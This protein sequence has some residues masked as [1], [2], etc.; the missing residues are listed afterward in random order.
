MH[1][2]CR[3]SISA[4]HCSSGIAATNSWLS[5]FL[6][7][8]RSWLESV[9]RTSLRL[10]LAVM[11]SNLINR[12][13]RLREQATFCSFNST[14]IWGLPWTCHVREHRVRRNHSLCESCESFQPISSFDESVHFLVFWISNQGLISYLRGN[15]RK[16]NFVSNETESRTGK[17]R[18]DQVHQ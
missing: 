12:A 13:T 4:A 11:P 16:C 1:S 18:L 3:R 6:F 14:C 5:L 10:C 7:T 8:G 17:W 15:S 9:V 2:L